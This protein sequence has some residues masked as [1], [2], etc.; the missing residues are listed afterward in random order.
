MQVPDALQRKDR[1][2]HTTRFSKRIDWSH[3]YNASGL[4]ASHID[5]ATLPT[6]VFDSSRRRPAAALTSSLN[7]RRDTPIASLGG[8]M[9]MPLL[10]PV[11]EAARLLDPIEALLASRG[12]GP[13]K[14]ERA[15][16]APQES[17]DERARR[18]ASIIEKHHLSLSQLSPDANNAASKRVRPRSIKPF[19][20]EAVAR[21]GDPLAAAPTSDALEAW[22]DLDEPAGRSDFYSVPFNVRSTAYPQLF[23]GLTSNGRLGMEEEAGGRR[24]RRSRVETMPMMASLSTTPTTAQL[25]DDARKWLDTRVIRGHAPMHLYGLGGARGRSGAGQAAND[26]TEGPL[27]GRD[28]MHEV[29]ER[30]EELLGAYDDDAADVAGVDDNV[31]TDEEVAAADDSDWDLSD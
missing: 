22:N 23:R 14:N 19:A 4:L 9:P 18:A 7:W 31:G 27:G 26:D 24:T 5:T 20:R 8:C 28:G 6:R 29:R 10:A 11:K 25:L 17:A 13:R 12:Y 30:L 15:G 1:S 2:E 16:E 21:D 3:M